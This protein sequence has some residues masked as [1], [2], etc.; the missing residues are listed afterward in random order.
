M[1]G[2]ILIVDDVATNRIV[3]KV[4]LAAACYDV[5]QAD[6]AANALSAARRNAPDLILLDLSLP[7]MSGLEACRRLK[8]DPATAGIP[9]ILVTAVAD[10]ASK[11]A[12]LEA[13]ADD[14]L[15]K[16]VDE[17]T[18]LARVRSLL[19][20]RDAVQ[21]LQARDACSAHLGF[22]EAMGGFSAQD[23][24]ARIALVAP[25]ARG[26]VIWKNAL[27]MRLCDEVVVL[28]REAAL[29]QAGN[30]A[31][32]VP[33]VFVIAADLGARNDGMRLLSDLRSRQHTRHAAAIMI[34]PEGDSERAASAL[35]LGASD[36]LFDPFDPQ[37]LAIRIRAQ[38]ARK[39]QADTL[40]ASVKAGLELAMTDSL[41]GLHNRRYALYRLEQMMARPGRGVAVMMLDLD[42]F[43]AINDRHGHRV[44]DQVLA[45][46]ARRL[47][48]QL[49]NRDLL[50][51]IGGE[52]FL[53]ALPFCDL[54]AA[55]DCAER[56]RHTIGHTTFEIDAAPAP[57]RVT[58]SVGLALVS[59]EPSCETPQSA[60]DRADR[61]LYGA[62]THGRDQVTL[63][64][65]PAA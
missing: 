35:D 62:K 61:A 19:R 56:L 22:A 46:V 48:A 45:L 10:H 5:D 29:S 37:E 16:P 15:T 65:R 32:E 1:T 40:R 41:T 17:V 9:V 2:R 53:V 39:R 44:G 23:R 14:F 30:A 28:P 27:D 7:D 54:K 55:M 60:I 64:N 58:L 42:Y 36:I 25:G 34:L 26:A 24:P 11:M 8:A 47:R 63:A 50:A 57:L 13:G 59:G 12:G 33:D 31:Q 20:A 52:E 21:D 6:T 3:M 49:R 38:L 43:K 51:R 4:K 18:L